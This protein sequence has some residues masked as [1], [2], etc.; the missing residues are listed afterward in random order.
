MTRFDS[1][2]IKIKSYLVRSVISVYEISRTANLNYL[3]IDRSNYVFAVL[4][5]FDSFSHSQFV[6]LHLPFFVKIALPPRSSSNGSA[7]TTI[8]AAPPQ[9]PR[10][11]IHL[12]KSARKERI[13]S[14]DSGSFLS[15]VCMQRLSRHR[16]SAVSCSWLA[17]SFHS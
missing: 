16:P 13:A 14:R 5:T 11:Q 15:Q 6:L 8:A 12:I 2:C 9:C 10:R 17:T 4:L 3:S 7:S 1:F